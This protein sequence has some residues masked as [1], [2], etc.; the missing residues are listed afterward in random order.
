MKPY[1]NKSGIRPLE[2]RVLIRPDTVKQVTDGGI[3]KPD[4]SHEMEQWAQVKGTL[5]AI[6]GSCFKDY[7]ESERAMLV[8]GVRVYYSKYSGINVPG[9][10]GEEYQLCTDKDVGGVVENESAVPSVKGRTRAGLDAA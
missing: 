10:D 7:S 6:G 4:K 9:A 1:Q 5:I 2:Y 3:W 8:P